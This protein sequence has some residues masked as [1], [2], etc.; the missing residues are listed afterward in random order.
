MKNAV[1]RLATSVGRGMLRLRS[2]MLFVGL[3]V[4]GACL[5]GCPQPEPLYG[6]V[7]L[8]GPPSVFTKAAPETEPA[9]AETEQPI[10]ETGAQD[11]DE[12]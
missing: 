1:S 8:Y 11:G 6:V 2:A 9:V 12:E 5:T 10:G 4:L 3:W 7:V